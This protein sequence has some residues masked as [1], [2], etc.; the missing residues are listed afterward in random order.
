MSP[1]LNLAWMSKGI[2]LILVWSKQE[3]GTIT[4]KGTIHLTAFAVLELIQA[5][6]AL[7]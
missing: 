4:E 2:L 7:C 3:A 1:S 5:L 6:F